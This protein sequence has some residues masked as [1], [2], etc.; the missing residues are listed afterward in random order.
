MNIM[1]IYSV[2]IAVVII[3]TIYRRRILK[4]ENQNKSWYY[5]NRVLVALLAMVIIPVITLNVFIPDKENLTPEEAISLGSKYENRNL[6]LR[7]LRKKAIASPNDIRAQIEYIQEFSYKQTEAEIN[8]NTLINLYGDSEEIHK[9]MAYEYAMYFC[10]EKEMNIAYLNTLPDTMAYV[11]FMKSVYYIQNKRPAEAEVS[12]LQEERVNPGF[13][14]TYMMLYQMY[15]LETSDSLQS[16]MQNR[17]R[18]KY[19]PNQIQ[20]DYHFLNGNWELYF[21]NLLDWRLSGVGL[22]TFIAAFVISFIWVVFLRTMDMYNR[23]KWRDILIVFVLA[24]FSTF[25]CLPI[26]DYARLV[27]NWTLNGDVWNDFMYCTVV[28]GG[29]EELVKVIPWILFGIYAK[30][31]REPFDYILYASVSALGFAFVENLMYLEHYENIVVRSIM[32]TVGHMFDAA[33]VAYAFIIVRFRMPKDSAWKWLVILGGFVVSML[34]HGFYDYWLISPAAKGLSAVTIVF[35]LLSLRVWFYFKNNAMNHSPFFAGNQKFR[36]T[37]QQDILTISMVTVL[38]LQFIFMSLEVGALSAMPTF[39]SGAVYVGIFVVF[40]SVEL[41]NF[42]LERGVWKR[43]N[44]RRK[45]GSGKLKRLLHYFSNHGY[46]TQDSRRVVTN[47]SGLKLRLF[48]PKTNPYLGDK[49]PVSGECIRMIEVGGSPD[50]YVFKLNKP[51]VFGS[52]VQDTI[53]VRN[54]RSDQS[55]TE[56]KVEI[57]FMFIPYPELLTRSKIAIE[58]LR[59][60]GRAYSRPIE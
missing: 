44:L 4:P 38:M 14:Q 59:Y 15:W 47:L 25:L 27:A 41:D 5:N 57:Y 37:L 35:F 60:A 28:I 18:S 46:T 30:K 16:L 51:V 36:I 11:N 20:N 50:W 45:F 9:R 22:F 12:L 54:K 39:I 40:I 42:K 56:D 26:Y 2:I 49:L 8:C 3:T 24:C 32:S 17:D 31:L 6:Y 53:I 52:Y 34:A 1:V 55:L 7:G 21:I 23:E 48:A 10:G 33:I 29:G 19:L 43:F 58:E 13:E